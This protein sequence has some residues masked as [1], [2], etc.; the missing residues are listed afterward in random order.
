MCADGWQKVCYTIE[1]T[2]QNGIDYE[3][4]TGCVYAL[5]GYPIVPPPTDAPAEHV[6]IT[7][8]PDN[9]V[10]GEETVRLVLSNGRCAQVIIYDGPTVTPTPM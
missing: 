2:A 7:P 9:I 1:G 5:V 10:E 6:D 8:I 3:Q 4:I